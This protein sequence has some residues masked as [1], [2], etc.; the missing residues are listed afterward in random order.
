MMKHPAKPMSLTK[1]MGHPVKPMVSAPKRWN[2]N[3]F[4][5]RDTSV[6]GLYGEIRLS[7]EL[8]ERGWQV[9]KAYSDEKFDFVILKS[10]C[11]NCEVFKSAWMREQDYKGRKSRAATQLCETCHQ[12]SLKMIVRFIQVKTSEGIEAKTT[13]LGE[14]TKNFSFHPKIRYHL[15]DSRVF[16]AWIQV[17]DKDTHDINY[18]IFK[19]SDVEHFDNLALDTYQITDNQKT[20]LRINR[21][22][23]VLNRGRIHNFGVFED[24]HNNFECLEERI[25]GDSW[26]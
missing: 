25:E 8:H 3:G 12:D 5:N 19:T 18:Y 11:E 24:F 6:I 7:M 26:K 14:E 17:W 13:E 20:T 2:V 1:T 4:G 23:E 21:A 22:G 9:Y 15:R 10:Y 16:Y